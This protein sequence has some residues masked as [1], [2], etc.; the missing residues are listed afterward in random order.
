MRSNIG[1][2]TSLSSGIAEFSSARYRSINRPPSKRRTVVIAEYDNPEEIAEPFRADYCV[3]VVGT[4][5]AALS[6]CLTCRVDLVITREVFIEG[7]NGVELANRLASLPSPPRVCL[8]TPFRL[9][10][11]QALPRFLPLEVPVISK[12]IPAEV[13]VNTASSLLKY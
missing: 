13:L 11:L 7:M 9:G 3:V 2:Q 6:I 5:D 4:A 8:V 1:S 10:T 12:P